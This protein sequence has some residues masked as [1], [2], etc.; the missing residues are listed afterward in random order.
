MVMEYIP[1]GELFSYLRRLKRFEESTAQ[2]YAAEVVLALEY[3]HTEMNVIYRDLKPENLLITKNGHIKI[4]DFGL[5]KNNEV[6]KTYCGTPE[7]LAPEIVKGDPYD[8]SVDLW[9]LGCLIFEMLAGYP[10]FTAKTR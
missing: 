1:G 4:T 7:Y 5:S 9:C 3:L 6:S 8:S 10:P 2:F